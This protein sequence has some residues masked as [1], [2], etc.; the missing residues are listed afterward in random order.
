MH[1][2]VDEIVVDQKRKGIE[3]SVTQYVCNSRQKSSDLELLLLLLLLTTL[4]FFFFRYTFTSTF[5][6]MFDSMSVEKL[7]L[8]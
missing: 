5:V 1:E 4:P 2:N 7:L 3:L 8:L 6:L